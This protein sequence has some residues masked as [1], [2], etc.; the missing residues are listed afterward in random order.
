MGIEQYLELINTTKCIITKQQRGLIC[1]QILKRGKNCNVLVFG[2]GNDSII[3]NT[4]NQ[5]Y[6]LFIE[7]DIK[8]ANAIKQ[9]VDGIQ[10]CHHEYLTTC[11]PKLPIH[12]QP[13]VDEKALI[14]HSMPQQLREKKWDVILVD[15]PTGFDDTCPGRTLPIYWSSLLSHADCDIF[16]DDYSRPIEFIYTNRFLFHKYQKY[17]LFEE[18][19]KMLWLKA[20]NYN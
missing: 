7:H 18:R 3:W 11:D 2:V 4:V 6:T 12:Q 16:I 1:K 17:R 13:P 5:G 14:S 19:W 15:G 8:W 10:I 20:E 9:K